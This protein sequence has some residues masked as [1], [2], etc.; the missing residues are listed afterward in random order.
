MCSNC[1]TMLLPKFYERILYILNRSKAIPLSKGKYHGLH[2]TMN[3][4]AWIQFLCTN[5]FQKINHKTLEAHVVFPWASVSINVS[6]WVLIRGGFLMGIQTVTLTAFIK[7]LSHRVQEPRGDRRRTRGGKRLLFTKW[8][9]SNNNFYLFQIWDCT[10]C[11]S[12]HNVRVPARTRT[13][14]SHVFIELCAYAGRRHYR[15]CLTETDG[16]GLLVWWRLGVGSHAIDCSLSVLFSSCQT[17][18]V[19]TGSY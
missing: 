4:K 19:S 5:W 12:T 7:E 15:C 2:I 8:V 18:R 17:D 10:I 16:G 1:R 11:T 9:L 14:L 3:D 13:L 6:W